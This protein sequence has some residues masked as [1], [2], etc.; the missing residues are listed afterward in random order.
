MN[1][2]NSI[3]NYFIGSYAE[4]KKVSW[5]T[6]KQLTTYSILVVAL[7]VGVA[8]FFAIADYILNLGIEQLINR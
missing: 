2:V 6:K 1:I 7:S 5:P 4:M 3:K 8:I